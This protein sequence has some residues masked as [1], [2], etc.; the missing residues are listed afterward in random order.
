MK[1]HSFFNGL[2]L[3][4]VFT[5]SLYPASVQAKTPLLRFPDVS[6]TSVV[7]V[8]GGD[9]WKA[10]LSGG[11]AVRLT[12]HDGDESMPKFSPDG[13]WIAFTGEYDGNPDV[14]IMDTNGGRIK[15]LTY[16]PGYDLVVGWNA[17]KNKIIFRS[18]RD[19][20]SRFSRLYMIN[21]DGSGLERLILHEAAQGSFSPDGS[22][23]AYNRVSRENR[24]WKRYQGGTAQEVYIYR[25]KTGVD[26]NITHFRG[27]DRIPM[28]M[29]DY[30]YF[31]SDRDRVLNIYAYNTINGTISQ[32][33]RHTRY[34]VRFPSMG[35]GNIVY[36]LGGDIWLLDPLNKETHK[37][38]I[39][40][41][42]DLPELRPYYKK[43]KDDVTA[44]SIS[45]TGK[46]LLV[47]ARGEIFS[48]PQKEGLVRNL[49]QTS[50]AREKDAV[51]SPDG[52]RIAYF[53]DASG[54]YQIYV[55]T[56]AGNGKAVQVSHVKPGYLH[57]LRWSPDSKKLAF[58]DE[59]LQL[60]I[61]DLNSQKVTVADKAAYQN[62]DI[63]LDKKAIYDFNWS[64]DSRFIAYSKMDSTLVNKL[65]IYSLEQH[66]TH[67]ISQGLF[68]DFQPVFSTD[69]AH[70]FFIS[71]RRF[72]PTYGDMEWEMVY[73]NIAG[74]YALTLAKN[75]APLFPLPN[76]EEK[77]N[78]PE[79]SK[80]E[81]KTV[82]VR[83][84][85]KGLQNRI[86]ALPLKRGNYRSLAVNESALFY[87]NKEKGDFNRFE[88]NSHF[89]M[90]LYAFSL[91]KQK[92]EPVL[93]KIDAYQLS[94]DG[95]QI[96]YRRRH[97]AGRL[98]ADK[99][100]A[101]AKFLSLDDLTMEMNPMQEWRQIFN[102]AWR[103]ER[104][105]YYEPGMHGVD[106]PAMKKKYGALLER[107]ASRQDL[108][109]L[110]G[111][112]IGELN[113]SH[114]Y[115]YGGDIQRRAKRVNVG[116]LG[117][118]YKTDSEHHLYQ[119][120]KIYRIPD[121]LH[122][123][124]APLNGPGKDLHTGD[125]LLEVN[126]QTIT[127][128]RNIYSYFTGLAG[129]EISLLV[130]K[131]PSLKGARSILVKPIASEYR[132]RYLDWLEH[133]RKVVEK[134]SNGQIGYLHLP[135]TY[136]GSA[137]IFPKY[138]YSQTT[139]KGLIVDGRYNGGGLDPDIFLQRLDKKPISFW[140]RRYTKDY[141]S[142]WLGNRAHL[143]CLTNRQAGS[144]GDELPYLFRLKGMGKVIGT[145][146]WGGLVGYSTGARLIDGGMITMPDY[147]IYNAQGKWVVENEGITPD[148]QID[149]KPAEMARGYDAQLMKAVEVLSKE[150]K[151]EPRPWPQHQP[152]PKDK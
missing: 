1:F 28:W 83:I 93:K 52:T 94:A 127:T 10:P 67:C 9:I 42:S 123:R 61:L 7:F 45:P 125:Y 138:Y 147:R 90:D 140:A 103:M 131:K 64:P 43:V 148:I 56:A 113:T 57:T 68:N 39:T 62:I 3:F 59:N 66:T 79:D 44:V 82:R 145:R 47:E 102:E 81:S 78:P 25:F 35:A 92:E 14:Y 22:Q 77:T 109:Y 133:N 29:G 111:E 71:N 70:L 151:A 19:S 143:V 48:V 137:R 130:N 85:F 152:Y 24:S 89:P 124:L 13:Q 20:Y 23:I 86:E 135:D 122:D 110:I 30:I 76:D 31:S 18:T 129:K 98:S 104:D 16:H 55:R 116:L 12:M 37:I 101:T 146:S 63:T 69:G 107:A 141:F 65:Y 96:V 75:G 108:R 2:F 105:F 114:T 5:L 150:I 115:I 36:Q 134:A 121:W 6:K 119:F 60:N 120:K 4:T 15:R 106:W 126:G 34:D 49:T 87:L 32:I 95:K 27:T 132:L 139:K 84:D 142:P 80:K 8:A 112:L 21:P 74:L 149:M 46:R 58:T 97:K 118:D 88:F 40:I 144:G 50:G 128:D 99:R 54:E 17:Q 72:E 91:N 100:N 11:E 136:N 26:T 51:W 53:S 117:A 73:K 41:G 33:T 38:P